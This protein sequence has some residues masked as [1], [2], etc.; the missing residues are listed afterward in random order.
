M[1]ITGIMWM[2]LGCG[3]GEVDALDDTA[4]SAASTTSAGVGYE[5][6]PDVQ[7]FVPEGYLPTAPVRVV[8]MGDS[9]TAGAGA[10]SSSLEYTSLLETNNDS[11]WPGHAEETLTDAY[12]TIEEWINVGVGGATPGPAAGVGAGDAPVPGN[13]RGVGEAPGAREIGLPVDERPLLDAPHVV[14][15]RPFPR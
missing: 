7:T 15:R 10:S 6:D 11:A 12:P 1:Y 9:I 8:Y 5:I 14:P 3:R 4:A 13:G 2:W